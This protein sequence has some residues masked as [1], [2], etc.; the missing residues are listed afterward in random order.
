M[1]SVLD[2]EAV[3]DINRAPARPGPSRSG[4]RPARGQG[5]ASAPR[6]RPASPVPAPTLASLTGTPRSRACLAPHSAAVGSTA[7][8]ANQTASWRLTDRGVSVVLVVLAM[9]AV[10]VL[11]VVVPTAIRV[12]GDNYQPVGTSQLV[13]P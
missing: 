2:L 6:L 3:G 11:A 12:T 1:M 10:A 7:V 13:R 5:R 9:V 8:I 4:G